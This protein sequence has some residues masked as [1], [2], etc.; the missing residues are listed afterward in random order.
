M[1]PQ[2]LV[3]LHEIGELVLNRTVDEFFSEVEQVAFCTS[4]VIPGVGFSDD[5]LLQGRNFSY[6]D[7]QITR[8]G[9]NWEQVCT[10]EMAP[11]YV[12]TLARQIPINRPVCP[13]LNHHRD[14]SGQHRIHKGQINYWPNRDGVGHPVP[15]KNGG[16]NELVPNSFQHYNAILIHPCRPM[17]GASGMKQRLRG[18]KFQEHYNH[19]QL[20]Y[21]SLSNIEKLHVVN[22]ISFELSHCDDQRVYKTYT[23]LLNNV[24]F[25]LAKMV[26]QNVN[27][28][29]PDKPARQ[30]HGK[31]DP[32]LS[33]EYYI[34]KKPTIATRRIAVLICDGFNLLE[35]EAVR[36]A[37]AGL[38]A[39][40]WII[41]P[42]RGRIFADGDSRQAIVADHHFEGQRST[43][44]DA[45]YIPSGSHAKSLASNGRAVHWIREA[46]GHCKAIGG[47]GEGV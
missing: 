38:Q 14:G 19:A 35:L 31:S 24:D 10:R 17:I 30:N 1:W 7:T 12:L 47:V 36:S 6:F 26:A 20:F 33:Q 9:V 41:G 15:V 29:I 11:V 13:V 42:R 16:Y 40:T 2:D 45:I 34:P 3:P 25:E 18:A 44:F 39:T 32:T 37:L 27:G 23:Q 22:A 4:H 43:L 21:N 8:L 5:P 46:F 28:I